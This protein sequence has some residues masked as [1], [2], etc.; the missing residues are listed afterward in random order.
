MFGMFLL[1]ESVKA[2]SGR[3]F[4]DLIKRYTSNKYK[5]VLSGSLATAILQ[6]S[7]AVTLII[8]AFVGAGFM[9]MG[10][11]IGVIIG[12]NLGTTI[13]TWIVATVGFKFKIEAFAMPLIGLGGLGLMFINKE[14][15]WGNLSKLMVGFGFLFFGLDMMKGS[16]EILTAGFHIEDLPKLGAWFYVL[17]GFLLTALLQSSS[18]SIAI[19]LTALFS[20]AL[21][22]ERAAAMVIGGNIGTTVTVLIGTINAEVIKK[23]VAYSHFLFNFLTALVALILLP[24]LI[25]LVNDIFS[26]QADPVMGLAVFH[27][28]FNLM[29]VLI[30]LPFIHQFSLLIIKLFPEKINLVTNFIHKVNLEVPE[31]SIEALQKEVHTMIEKVIELNTS[32]WGNTPLLKAES[33]DHLKALQSSV[34]QYAST[35]QQKE[36]NQKEGNDLIRILHSARYALA[37]AKICNDTKKYIEELREENNVYASSIYNRYTKNFND[38]SSSLKRILVSDDFNKNELSD[39]MTKVYSLDE[40]FIENLTRSIADQHLNENNISSIINANRGFILSSRQLIL[41]VRTIVL[42]YNEDTPMHFEPE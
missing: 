3:A 1:E 32:I 2:L 12:A 39:L 36:L 40:L 6:S 34:F 30:F 11:A 21:D 4:K 23:R 37:S 14:G 8:L 16:L 24:I 42:K 29:G 17:V 15:K 26:L 9:A 18:A 33:Y 38:I 25:Y 5:A 7:S 13:T 20:D 31:A 27:T 28:I 19:I 41:S 35:V 10:N 22:F